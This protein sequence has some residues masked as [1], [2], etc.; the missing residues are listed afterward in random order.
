MDVPCVVLGRSN[1]QASNLLAVLFFF[2]TFSPLP[3]PQ[4]H[5]SHKQVHVKNNL[6][7][8]PIDHTQAMT[9][10]GDITLFQGRWADIGLEEAWLRGDQDRDR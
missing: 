9:C 2:S 4:K 6:S 1:F 10:I 5:E 3:T 8:H 7:S